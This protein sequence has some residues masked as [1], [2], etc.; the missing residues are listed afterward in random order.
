M[1]AFVVASLGKDPLSGDVFV[2]RG[3]RGDQIKV[4]WFSGDGTNLYVKKLERGR[5]VWPSASDGVAKPPDERMQARQAGAGPI[6]PTLKGRLRQ[7]LN[8][9]PRKLPLAKAIHYALTRWDALLRY[10]DDGSIE[11]DNNPIEREIRPIALGRK[12][13]L[14]AGSDAGGERAAMMYSL[15]NTAKLNGIEPG[16]YLRQV[17][18]TTSDYPVNRVDEL[19]PWNINIDL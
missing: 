12:N 16:A 3:H 11:I 6:L 2:F 7:T 13:Y 5:F 9:V 19:L 14:F 10:I 4:L 17:L 8:R 18:A 1:T 15:I